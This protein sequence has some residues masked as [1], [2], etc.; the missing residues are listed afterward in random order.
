MNG[1][2]PFSGVD[3]FWEVGR[4]LLY[5][6]GKLCSFGARMRSKTRTSIHNFDED[7]TQIS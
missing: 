6:G 3:V 5:Y 4:C 7:S 1:V 2:D